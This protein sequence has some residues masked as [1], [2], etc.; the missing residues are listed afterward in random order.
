MAA[1]LTTHALSKTFGETRALS[2]VSIE[3]ETG[4]VYTILGENGSGKSTLVKSLSGIIPADKGEIRIEGSPVRPSGP[5][6]MIER[7]ISVVL[8]EVLIAPN[9]SGLENVL[10]GCDTLLS[11]GYTGA[12]RREKVSSLIDRL[13]TRKIDLD[14]PAGELPLNEQQV[15]VIARGFLARPR[16]LILDEITAAL[17]LS[18][19]NKVFAEIRSFCAKGGSV[20]FVSHRMPEIMELSDVVYVMHNGSQ[21][22]RLAGDDINPKTLLAHLTQDSQNV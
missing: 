12:E 11:Y 1:F 6:D 16:L 18:D 14:C 7:G 5:K 17:D 13:S 4:Y 2:E 9:R 19:R 15:L 21:T 8:Q 10:I 20:V 22:A 3:L